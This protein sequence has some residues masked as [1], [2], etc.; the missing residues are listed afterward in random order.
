MII[1]AIGVSYGTAKAGIAATFGIFWFQFIYG[2]GVQSAPW[3][4][5][6][7]MF[8]LSNSNKAKDLCGRDHP[9][10]ASSHCR[11]SRFCIRLDLDLLCRPGHSTR[12]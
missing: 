2:A 12:H 10:Q 3:Y 9:S 5:L 11:C 7:R 8:E 1:T 6:L 4:V